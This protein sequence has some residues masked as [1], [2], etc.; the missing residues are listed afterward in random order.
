MSLIWRVRRYLRKREQV[1]GVYLLCAAVLKAYG[2]PSAAAPLQ[3]AHPSLAALLWFTRVQSAEALLLNAV[4]LAVRAPAI[5]ITIEAFI[6]L[7]CT[8]AQSNCACAK[9]KVVSGVRRCGCGLRWQCRR[10]ASSSR[11]AEQQPSAPAAA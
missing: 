7:T 8:G 9:S 1:L 4:M 2:S 6:C 11:P 3:H 5:L 10:S